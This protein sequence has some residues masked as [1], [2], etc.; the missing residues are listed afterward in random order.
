MNDIL[1]PLHR[2][3]LFSKAK[4]FADY[5]KLKVL[6]RSVCWQ[7]EHLEEETEI[8]NQLPMNKRQQILHNYD[9]NNLRTLGRRKQR[10]EERMKEYETLIQQDI[11]QSKKEL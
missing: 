3:E 8:R 5:E 10:L 9:M 4:R 1:Y 7:I 11:D 6:H 2:D